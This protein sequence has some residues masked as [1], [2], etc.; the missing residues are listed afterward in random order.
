MLLAQ[1]GTPSEA[2]GS[3][4]A[5]LP[6]SGVGTSRVQMVEY[7]LG[8]VALVILVT[9][10]RKVMGGAAEVSQRGD[11]LSRGVR[12]ELKQ[13]EDS[14]DHAGA[15]ELLVAASRFAEAAD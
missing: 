13:R 7:G 4:A 10:V 14:G 6:D 15:A 9:V 12:V 3:G 11:G 5:P 1:S 2:A 8:V